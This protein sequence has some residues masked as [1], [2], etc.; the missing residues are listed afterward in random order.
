MATIYCINALICI[1]FHTYEDVKFIITVPVIACLSLP[2][3]HK[4]KKQ[5]IK[6]YRGQQEYPVKINLVNCLLSL[7]IFSNTH[8]SFQ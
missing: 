3:T 5:D 4:T 7:T 6:R 8:I 1:H 2:C